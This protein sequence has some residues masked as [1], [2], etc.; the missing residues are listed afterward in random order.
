MII[1]DLKGKLTLE[2]HVSEDFLTSTVFSAFKYLDNKWVTNFIN[3]AVNIKGES[4]AVEI[5][6]PSYKFWPYYKHKS[7][8]GGGCEPDLIIYTNNKAIIIEAKNY[9]DKSGKG[10]MKNVE[11]NVKEK[12][13]VDQLGREYFVGRD[14]I[15]KDFCLVFL[16]RHNSFPESDIKESIQAIS[17]LDSSEKRKAENSIYWV[18][19]YQAKNIFEEIRELHSKRTFNYKISEDLC[20]F[21]D[22]RD[23]RG[24]TGFEII[25]DY[26]E[27]NN[28]NDKIF[29]NKTEKE[30]WAW[31]NSYGSFIDAKKFNDKRNLFYRKGGN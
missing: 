31:L 9:S 6:N 22:R 19:W 12:I 1:A 18:N 21:L 7:K 20:K 23:L 3:Q 11:G 10:L 14:K 28:I 26:I 2:E 13:L 30:F 15:F 25:D 29:Y 8:F 16:T 4:L 5:K 27:F 24:F 17:E